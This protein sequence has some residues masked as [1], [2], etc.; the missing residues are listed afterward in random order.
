VL[1]EQAAT[2][3]GRNH[4]VYF[5]SR[6]LREVLVR[7]GFDVVRTRT[8]VAS[9]DPVLERLTYSEPYSDAIPDD[10]P[11]VAAAR[12]RRGEIEGLLEQLD[13]GYKLHCL[14]VKST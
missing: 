1:H 7:G 14:A 6:T 13:L 11:L 5:S 12:E 3:D 10:D 9:L 4:L 2:F 8:R